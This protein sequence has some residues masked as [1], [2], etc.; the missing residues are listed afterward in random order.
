MRVP[1]ALS[2]GSSLGVWFI[3]FQKPPCAIVKAFAEQSGGL[4]FMALHFYEH[5]VRMSIAGEGILGLG[6][7]YHAQHLPNKRFRDGASRR[8][9]DSDRRPGEPSQRKRRML[10]HTEPQR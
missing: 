4:N 2:D 9:V 10:N 6:E 7:P 3:C 5:L 1:E 8:Q